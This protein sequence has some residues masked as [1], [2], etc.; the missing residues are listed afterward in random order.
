MHQGSCLCKKV[1]FEIDGEFKGFYLCH[2]SRC[3]KA[4][5]SAHA[6]NL[7]SMSAKLN[8]VSGRDH[9]KTFH[10]EGTRFQKS[11]CDNCG[12]ALPTLHESGRLL[13][14]TGCLD[15]E[16]SMQPTAHIFTGSRALWDKDLETVVEFAAFPG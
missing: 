11:F 13:V 4:T 12:S 15:S 2:C 3:R 1:Q 6:S 10:L 7:F 16:M 5:G 9:V 14:P 8:W